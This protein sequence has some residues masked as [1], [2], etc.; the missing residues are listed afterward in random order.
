[1]ET[2]D[3]IYVNRLGGLYSHRGICCGDDR[4]IH[5]NGPNWL[6]SSV[7]C[8]SLDDFARG[9]AVQVRDYTSFRDELAALESDRVASTTRQLNAF[10]D[11]LRGLTVADL[12]LSAEAV[13]RRAESRLGETGFNLGLNNCEHFASWCKTG[14]SSSRQI[15]AVWRRALNPGAYLVHR[16]SSFLSARLDPA[17]RR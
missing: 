2:G 10:L 4:V 5:F 13:I 9:D 12:D 6:E 17:S 15:E 16:G 7:H 11:R 1:M 14:I 3:H 8:A